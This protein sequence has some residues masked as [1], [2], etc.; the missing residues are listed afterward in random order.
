ME[1][2]VMSPARSTPDESTY[3]GRIGKRIRDLREA[4]RITL[5]EMVELLADHGVE[6][7]VTSL[8]HWEIGRAK[9][10]LDAM[11]AIA[12]CLGVDT[13]KIMPKE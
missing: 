9:I 1:S 13:H 3:S 8:S 6:V 7:S 10:H 12:L 5:K 11:P 4:K 2:P